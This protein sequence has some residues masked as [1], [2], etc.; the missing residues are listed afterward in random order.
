[1]YLH[2]LKLQGLR[3]LQSSSISLNDG[4]NIFYGLNG[5]GK[6]SV[7]EAITLLTSGRSFR[8]AKLELVLSDDQ[9]AFTLFGV[10]DAQTK[11]GIGYARQTKQRSIKLNGEKINSLSQLSKLYPTQVL[12]PESYHLID[13]GPAERRK[14]IDWCLFHVEHSYHQHWKNYNLVLSQRN[15]LLKQSAQKMFLQQLQHW[16]QQLCF[17]ETIITQHRVAMLSELQQSF[18]EV[19]KSLSVNFCDNFELNYYPGFTG[20]FAERLNDSLALDREYGYTR[21]GPHKADI[22]IKINGALAKDFLSRGQKKVIVNALYLAQT[23]LLKKL[24][25]KDSLF[26]IDDFSSE[27]DLENQQLLLDVLMTQ[28]NLQIIIS[29]LQLDS[30]NWLKKRYNSAHMFHVE[31]GVITPVV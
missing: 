14:F 30:L 19:I 1:M 15:A 23:A 7:L 12:S 28:N 5:A 22:R 16:N 13:S 25:K 27:L 31:R 20:S 11:V 3:N 26:I 21:F 8:T 24:S 9:N 2:S 4:L 10:L 6:S 18:A 29:C 17:A